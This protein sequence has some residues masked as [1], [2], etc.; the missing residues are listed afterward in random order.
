VWIV[1][2]TALVTLVAVVVGWFTSPG[3]VPR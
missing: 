3:N 1:I 2:G